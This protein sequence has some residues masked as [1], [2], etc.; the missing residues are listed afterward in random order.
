[1]RKLTSL[2]SEEAFQVYI[3]HHE[4]K[5]RTLADYKE[6]IEKY[7]IDLSELKLIDITEQMIEEKVYSVISV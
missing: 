5:E 7:L 3:N 1:M 6:V 4:L 2:I